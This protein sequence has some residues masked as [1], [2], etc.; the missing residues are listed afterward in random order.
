MDSSAAT[1]RLLVGSLMLGALP[2]FPAWGRHLV[3]PGL[4]QPTGVLDPARRMTVLVKLNGIGPFSFMIDTGANASVVSSEVVAQLDLARGQQVN[5]HGVAGAELVDTVQM[6]AV[7]VG[8]R[9]RRKLT[10][11]VLPQMNLGAQGVLGL[12]WL[13]EQGLTL[14]FARRQ[15]FLGSRLPMTDSRTVTVPVRSQRS[16]LHLIDARVM[17]ITTMAYLD[18]GSTMTIGN[19]ALLEKAV[20]YKALM[21]DW[22]DIEVRSVTGQTM[23]GRL[24]AFKRLQLGNLILT[25]VPVVFGPIHTFDYWG[26]S[27]HPALLIGVDVLNTFES[28]ALDFTRG[29]VH[30][31]LQP[32][33][34][35]G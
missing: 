24:A 31:R 11:S 19:S 12:D 16:G 35:Y 14:D 8:G 30:F 5:M 29:Q 27:R 26:L 1:R 2:A 13:G 6:D 22:A 15:M 4:S 17:G 32:T 9:V 3:E 18:T 10:M 20:K 7:A 25:T 28:V 34:G 21:R 33:S 23:Q